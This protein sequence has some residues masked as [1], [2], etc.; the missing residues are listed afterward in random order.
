[1]LSEL[2]LK[3]EQLGYPL[4]RIPGVGAIY[5]PVVIDRETVYTSGSVPFDGDRLLFPGKV[6]STVSLED[7]RTAAAL[8]AANILRQVRKH[9]GSLDR[10]ERILRTVGYVNCDPDFDRQHLVIN[11]ASELLREIFG[12]SGVGARTALGMASLPLGACVEVD[13]VL[14]LK[15]GGAQSL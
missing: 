11:G 12:E 8:C 3:L 6:P 4:E 15:A 5:K 1:M 7:A 2:D 10:V 14:K 9:V 13:I